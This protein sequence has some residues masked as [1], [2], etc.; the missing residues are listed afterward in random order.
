MQKNLEKLK[1]Y[2]I[3][4]FALYLFFTFK[5]FYDDREI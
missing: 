5:V 1:K 4:C 2:V 3:R